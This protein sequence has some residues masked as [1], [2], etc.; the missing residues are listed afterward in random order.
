MPYR[1]AHHY[2]LIVL[3]VIGL[4]FWPS[5]FSAIGHLPRN[6]MRTVSP[7]VWG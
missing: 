7:P 5:Y 1:L 4:G 6:F 2:V 3:A